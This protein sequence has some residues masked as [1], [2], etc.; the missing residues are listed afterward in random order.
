MSEQ[1]LYQVVF[2][3]GGYSCVDYET[4]NYEQAL[5]VMTELR[6]QMYIAGERNFDY[7]IKQVRKGE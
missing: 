7:I 3:Q 4:S 6:S 1:V 5:E 2:V